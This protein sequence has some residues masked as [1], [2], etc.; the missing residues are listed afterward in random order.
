[1]YN[2]QDIKNSQ[3]LHIAHLNFR[4]LVNKWDN[5]KANFIDSGLHILT[6]S[7][8]WL[9]NELPD[10]LFKIGPEYSLIRNDRKWNDSNNTQLP[11]KREG[12]KCMCVRNV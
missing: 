7:E 2:F 5:I 12:A 8:T 10:A 4:S 1:M 3:G 6:F 9:N 11:P